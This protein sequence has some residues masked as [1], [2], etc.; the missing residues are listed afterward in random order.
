MLLPP[1]LASPPGAQWGATIETLPYPTTGCC[2]LAFIEAQ[3]WVEKDAIGRVMKT[4]VPGLHLG[5]LP[6][7]TT[8]DFM[9]APLCRPEPAG[10]RP[11]S[12]APQN[13][14]DRLRCGRG[15]FPRGRRK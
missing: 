3:N 8:A 15:R 10:P 12:A 11:P 7:I 6:A 9:A 14:R 13:P 4:A 5:S 2:H 1:V